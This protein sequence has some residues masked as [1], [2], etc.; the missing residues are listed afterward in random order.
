M[1]VNVQNSAAA[2]VV[3][4]SSGTVAAEPTE[5]VPAVVP[6]AVAPGTQSM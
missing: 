6:P 2:S 1:L 4:A 3:E 5:V